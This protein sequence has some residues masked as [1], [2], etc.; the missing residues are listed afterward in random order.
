MKKTLTLTV[1]IPR[2]YMDAPY[3]EEFVDS[4]LGDYILEVSRVG[5]DIEMKLYSA[6]TDN[7]LQPVTCEM[8]DYSVNAWFH[9]PEGQQVHVEVMP[10]HTIVS[11]WE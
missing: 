9:L 8:D 3:T 4:V 7:S 10:K 2:G 11:L 5:E 1:E 6:V